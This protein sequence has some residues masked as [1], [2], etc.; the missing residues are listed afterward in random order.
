MAE[1]EMVD[2]I[3]NSMD[4]SLSEL[5]EVVKDRETWGAT[6]HGVANSWT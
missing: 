6:V 3:T 1:D 4:T 5:W 2:G